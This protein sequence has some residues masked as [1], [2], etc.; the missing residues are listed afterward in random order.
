MEG[1]ESRIRISTIPISPYQK[2]YGE[3]TGKQLHPNLKSGNTNKE[4]VSYS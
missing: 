4:L 3:T 1:E 2:W